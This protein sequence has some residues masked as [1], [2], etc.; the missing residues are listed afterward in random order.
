MRRSVNQVICIAGKN[1]I[2]VY[3]LQLALAR[4]EKSNVKVVCNSTDRG[5]DTWQPSLKKAAMQGGVEVIALEECFEIEGLVLISLEFEKII[6]PRKFTRAR[7]YNLH[8]SKLPAYKGMHTSVLPLLNGEKESGVTLHE[9]DAGIDTGDLI[10]QIVFEIDQ[11]DTARDL[12]NKY[13]EH[14]KTLLKNNFSNLLDNHLQPRPQS[15]VGSTYFS[16]KTIDYQNVRINLNNTATEITNQI[17]AYT[18][19]EYQLPRVHGCVVSSFDITDIKSIYQSG[20]LLA[21]NEQWLLISSLDFDVYLFRDKDAE[22]SEAAESNNEIAARA[23]LAC[24]ALVDSRNGEG[25]TPLVIAAGNGAVDVMKVLI[26][27]GADI[28][29]ASYGGETPLMAAIKWYERTGNS[30]ALNLLQKYLA[31]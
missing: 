17:R 28:N 1:E 6:P 19:P 26:E 15:S 14:A 29:L 25:S 3:G 9:I 10:D 20:S 18:F 30:L 22:L 7:L 24:G 16:R 5:L 27:Y 8:F 12:Y 4:A 21:V 13:L 2:A 23:C 11:M 31:N